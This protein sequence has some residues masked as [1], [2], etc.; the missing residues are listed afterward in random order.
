MACQDSPAKTFKFESCAERAEPAAPELCQG[1]LAAVSPLDCAG[2]LLS[3]LL[4]IGLAD[5][6]DCD[7]DTCNSSCLL[8]CWGNLKEF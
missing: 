2:S 6:V 3:L 5:S 7:A 1:S 4:C 8:R